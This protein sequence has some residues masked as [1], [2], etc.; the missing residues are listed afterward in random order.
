VGAFAG[1]VAHEEGH[2]PDDALSGLRLCPRRP[3]ALLLGGRG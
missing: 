2:D 1:G 3:G